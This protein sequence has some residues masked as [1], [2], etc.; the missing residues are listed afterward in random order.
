MSCL[1]LF[2]VTH[3]P[4]EINNLPVLVFL[5]SSA[6]TDGAETSS[7]AFTCHPAIA[8]TKSWEIR[9][10]CFLWLSLLLTVPF[11][12]SAFDA[13]PS[14]SSESPQ[15]EQTIT[16]RILT[17]GK[18]ALSTPSKEGEYAALVLARLFARTDGVDSMDGFLGWVAGRLGA[19]D[20]LE[21]EAVFVSS[22]LSVC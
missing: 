21:D 17:I 19:D 8:P 4:P 15:N 5:L 16:S 10:V 22:L 1:Y 12:L 3:F 20:G 9:S 13:A 11:N 14:S 18:T 2:A 7:E 6:T